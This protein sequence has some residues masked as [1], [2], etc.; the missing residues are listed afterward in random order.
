MPVGRDRLPA[1][2]SPHR[3]LVETDCPDQR[4]SGRPAGRNLPEYLVDVV[5][6]VAEVRGEPAAVVA[7][8]CAFNAQTLYGL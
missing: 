7:D 6:T 3:L 4:P 1:A 2:V 5:S 8:R